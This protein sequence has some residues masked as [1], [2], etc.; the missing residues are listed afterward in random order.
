MQRWDWEENM[1][2][3]RDKSG[4]HF[5]GTLLTTPFRLDPTALDR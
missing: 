1:S 3:V 2:M 5:D 4:H